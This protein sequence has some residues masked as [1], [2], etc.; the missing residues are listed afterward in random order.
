VGN[1]ILMNSA[2]LTSHNSIHHFYHLMK[3]QDKARINLSQL[4][5][6]VEWGGG[7]EIWRNFLGE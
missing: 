6:V 2:Y 1:P 5:I 3:F 4:G 7:M